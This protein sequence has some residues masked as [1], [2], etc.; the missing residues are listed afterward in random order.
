MDGWIDGEANGRLMEEQMND[1]GMEGWKLDQ[2][3]LGAARA[4]S[5]L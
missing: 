2:Y 4:D 1:G 3:Q 5:L